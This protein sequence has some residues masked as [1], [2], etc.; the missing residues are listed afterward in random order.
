MLVRDLGRLAYGPAWELQRGAR[1]ALLAGQ[2]P[3][4]LFLVEHPPVLT[5]GRSSRPGDLGLAAE[6]W[7]RRGV[8]VVAVDRGGRATYHGPGQ[9]VAYPVVDLGRRGRDLRAYVAA[10]E[11]AAVAAARR[12]GVDARPGRDPVGVF[13]GPAKVASVGV[14]VR[15]WVT[16]HGLSL[17]VT[18]DLEVYRHFSA[19]GLAGVPVTRL[20][21]LAAV[22]LDEARAAL[23]AELAARLAP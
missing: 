6:E 15:R 1:E 4:V 17:N 5:L 2:G 13:V 14:S 18:C 9:V 7:G 12:F 8:E 22:T 20:A 16:A 10:L 19:C 11:D 23:A 3:E 21:D